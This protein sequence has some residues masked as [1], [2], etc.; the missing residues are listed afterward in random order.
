MDHTI[1]RAVF[2]LLCLGVR[3]TD[4]VRLAIV[5]P[6]M[7]QTR[8]DRY[9][10]NV[11]IEIFIDIRS[12]DTVATEGRLVLEYVRSRL[13]NQTVSIG[14][15]EREEADTLGEVVNLVDRQIQ[16]IERVD[17]S[18]GC[19]DRIVVD[20]AVVIG[21]IAPYLTVA[22]TDT[23]PIRV[24]LDRVR[25]LSQLDMQQKGRV[26]TRQRMVNIRV[27]TGRRDGLTVPI[28]RLTTYDD[29]RVLVSHRHRL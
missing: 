21:I 12:D 2:G 20:T 7:C 1:H 26:T 27:V 10:L 15:R 8:T 23:V 18:A 19:L 3:T 6:D 24:G 16:D 17:L 29:H 5:I 28:Q 14:N 25:R 11:V 13:L 9:C 22:L 4:A